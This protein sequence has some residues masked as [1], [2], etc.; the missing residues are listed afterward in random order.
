MLKLHPEQQLA[1]HGT[2][3]A[4]TSMA[5]DRRRAALVDIFFGRRLSH[6]WWELGAAAQLAP[7]STWAG[8]GGDYN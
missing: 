4:G 6:G 3:A 2:W 5:H 1:G 8:G 7:A